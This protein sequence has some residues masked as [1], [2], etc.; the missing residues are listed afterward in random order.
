LINRSVAPSD[1][2]EEEV[3]A[4]PAAPVYDDIDGPR[5]DHRGDTIATLGMSALI[6]CFIPVVS[7][8]LAIAALWMAHN[9]LREMHVLVRDDTQFARMFIRIG[10]VC[11]VLALVFSTALL[12]WIG[13][14]PL[15]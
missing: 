8:A 11:S 7:H 13:M 3:A 5:R 2:P 6:L 4:E 14:T 1:I 12:V 10:Q 15:P 9:D